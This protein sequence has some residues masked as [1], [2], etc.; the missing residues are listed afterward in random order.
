MQNGEYELTLYPALDALPNCIISRSACALS[1]LMGSAGAC[2]THPI[3][4]GLRC[5]TYLHSKVNRA[6]EGAKHGP[7]EERTSPYLSA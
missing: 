6:R 1:H 4:C 2:R 7:W 3:L 5:K